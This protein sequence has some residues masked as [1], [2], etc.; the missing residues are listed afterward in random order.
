MIPHIIVASRHYRGG[1]TLTLPSVKIRE[2]DQCEIKQKK[3][4][5]ESY[6]T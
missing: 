2:I 3:K 1:L 6:I 5:K 4:Y